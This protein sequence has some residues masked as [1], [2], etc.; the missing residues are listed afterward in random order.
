[1]FFALCRDGEP[2]EQWEEDEKYDFSHNGSELTIRKV[3]KNDEAEYICIAENKAGEHD[4]TIHLKVF[5]K[6]DSHR[7]VTRW[8]QIDLAMDCSSTIGIYAL[9]AEDL[10]VIY[11]AHDHGM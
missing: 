5:G 3:D 9:H 7:L 1:M 8:V 2:I 10:K 4:A 11:Q 6:P